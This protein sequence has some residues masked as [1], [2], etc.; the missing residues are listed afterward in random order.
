MQHTLINKVS[1]KYFCSFITGRTDESGGGKEKRR[2]EV[3]NLSPVK[4][5]NVNY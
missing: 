4:S 5:I 1:L 2:T 3:R